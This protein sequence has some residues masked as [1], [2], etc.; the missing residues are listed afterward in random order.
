MSGKG[1]AF[2]L[3]AN[4]SNGFF[5][6]FD[7]LY[8]SSDGWRA[9]I[10]KGGPG[11]GKSGVMKKIASAAEEKGFYVEKII[12]SGD[13]DSLD[14]IIIPQIKICFADGTAP[15]TMEPQYPGAVEEIINLGEC[16]NSRKLFEQR[17]HIL[18]ITNCNKALHKQSARYVGA[19]S[20]A[21]ADS[22]KIEA[23]VAIE[24][25]A[26]NYATRFISRKCS[27]KN[28]M[29]TEQKRFLSGVSPQGYITL[30]D[31]A[32]TLCDEIYSVTDEGY[33]ASGMLMHALCRCAVANG[34][35]VISCLN[36]FAPQGNPLHIIFPQERIG[37]FTSNSLQNFKPIAYKNINATRF[38]DAQTLSSYKK[39]LE[40]NKKAGT[41]LL[42]EAVCLLEKAKKVHDELETYYINAMDFNLLNEMT[43]KIIKKIF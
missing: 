22:A 9:Y 16:W 4:S 38:F 3:A 42:N 20:T 7:E 33:Y 10:I 40:F 18:T 39:R 24:E 34:I 17:E 1:A 12:C 32:Q 41:Q 29:G 13:P 14:A 27:C 5:S 30:F 26:E 35:D 23:A 11:T 43:D 6:L 2:F 31:T 25:K 15:H 19:C 37:F 8:D 21:F 28:S 36:P